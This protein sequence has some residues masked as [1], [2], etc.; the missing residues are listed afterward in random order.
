MAA[1]DR[2][3]FWQCVHAR[4]RTQS[5]S[6]AAGTREAASWA[7]LVAVDGEKSMVSSE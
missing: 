4:A 5:E 6:H 3:I 7:Y 1:D 2:G